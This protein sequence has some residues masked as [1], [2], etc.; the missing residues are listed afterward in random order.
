MNLHPMIRTRV[1]PAIAATGVATLLGAGGWYG[2]RAVSDRPVRNVVFTGDVQALPADVLEEFGRELKR[3]TVGTSL[4]SVRENARRIPWVRDASVRRQF[5][6][7][8]EVRFAAY[9][10]LAR[11]NDRQLVS[12]S[13]DVFAG[14]TEAALPAFR[15]P[16]GMALAMSTLYPQLVQA[17]AP[18]GSA[19]AHLRL[20]PRGAWEVE[21]AS[22]LR[23][24]LGRE[25]MAAR[26]QRLAATWPQLAARG[27]DTKYADLRYANGFALRQVSAVTPAPGQTRAGAGLIPP[28]KRKTK[29]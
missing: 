23:I 27:I 3:R 21:L 11:W 26:A 24:E 14:T 4:D 6:D 9:Q 10:A 22:G 19:I 12:P 8:I 18:L 13:G 16:D 7:T 17:L 1:I 15:G 29:R 5:P 25:E 20:S 2:Y 28:G